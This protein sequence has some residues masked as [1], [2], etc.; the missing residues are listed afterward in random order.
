MNSLPEQHID[1]LPKASRDAAYEQVTSLWTARM[2]GI[3]SEEELVEKAGFPSA[4]AM[5]ANLGNW[6]LY[7]LLPP[8]YKNEAPQERKRA[9]GGEPSVDLP[10]LADAAPLFREALEELSTEVRGLEHWHETYD[11]SGRFQATY[12]ER[13]LFIVPRAVLELLPEEQRRAL[14]EQLGEMED[15]ET[16]AFPDGTY[17]SY[18]G[19]TRKPQ[20]IQLALI[21]AYALTGR[22]MKPLIEALN[23]R[24]EEVDI[25][26]IEDLVNKGDRSLLHIAED[27]ARAVKHSKM[28]RGRPPDPLSPEEQQRF[29]QST[30]KGGA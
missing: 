12:K 26:V 21:A 24:P 19:A 6:G 17:A 27:L 10:P 30:K 7:G 8:G 25:K 18:K 29:E 1:S 22:S 9:Q 23:L 28:A 3:D 14:S 16:P 2:H 20:G 15:D 5:Y 11:K 4:E 13:G